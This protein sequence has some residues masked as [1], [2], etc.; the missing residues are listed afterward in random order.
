MNTAYIKEGMKI[1]E[2]R[3][4][5]FLPKSNGICMYLKFEQNIFSVVSKTEQSG[6]I[7][8]HM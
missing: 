6:F 1:E 5:Q 7:S 3:N 8:S 4:P 2:E